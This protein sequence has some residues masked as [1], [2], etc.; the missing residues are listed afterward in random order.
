MGKTSKKEA[1]DLVK[2]ETLPEIKQ[3]SS[4]YAKYPTVAEVNAELDREYG[5]VGNNV[6]NIN[7]AILR[8][9]VMARLERRKNNG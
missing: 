3:V 6:T 8:E 2:T 9:L 1:I 4:T 5:W 7:K